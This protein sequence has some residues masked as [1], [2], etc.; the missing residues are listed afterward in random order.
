[1]RAL[2]IVSGVA[3][4]LTTLHLGH[5]VHHFLKISSHEGMHGAVLFTTVSAAVMG[6]DTF[7]Y[8]RLFVVARQPLIFAATLIFR[9]P[10]LWPWVACWSEVTADRM[11]IQ[12]IASGRII[13]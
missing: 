3:V 11:I 6:V 9:N 7:V 5:G 8:W 2:Q 10:G 1:M 4:L 12:S 13:C